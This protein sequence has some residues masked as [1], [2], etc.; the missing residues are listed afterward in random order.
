M[1]EMEQT[2]KQGMFRA[3]QALSALTAFLL[4]VQPILIG[5]SLYNDPDYI[6]LHA[7]VANGLTL[8]VALQ[9]VVCFLGRSK[10]GFATVIWNFVLLVLI[11]AQT[12]LGYSA[13]DSDGA[14]Q[15]H[16]PLGVL[17]FSLGLIIALLGFFDIRRQ[18][19]PQRGSGPRP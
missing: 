4:I 16:I 11:V 15:V 17:M 10:W 19:A 7:V 8:V 6:D 3:Y 13:R 12:G 1:Q 9:L 18:G 14:A 2:A 5:Q